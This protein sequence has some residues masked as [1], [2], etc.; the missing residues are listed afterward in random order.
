LNELKLNDPKA[1]SLTKNN[2]MAAYLLGQYYLKVNSDSAKKY[3]HLAKELDLLRFR[4]PERINDVIVNLAEKYACHLVNMKDVFLNY[5]GQGVVGDELLT[6]HVHPNIEGYFVMADAFY[7][8]IKELNLIG[9]WD[10]YISFNEAFKDIPLTTID[11]LNGK[12]VIDN[13]KK[14][15]PFDLNRAGA[16]YEAQYFLNRKPTFEQLKAHDIFKNEIPR[17]EVMAQ[18]YEWYKFKG[19]YEQCLRIVQTMILDFPERTR[20]YFLAGDICLKLNDLKKAVY[21]FSKYNQFEKSSL[22]AQQLANVYIK[23]NQIKMA[24]KTLMEAKSRGLKDEALIKML[25][26]INQTIE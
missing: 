19:N 14:S 6:E 22:S 10:N 21:Y 2:A 24:C 15:W 8:K 25:D 20:L 5:T 12:M 18:S 1:I 17:E 3:L 26:D 7:N 23:S 9:C 11:S 16:L 4:A 13:L